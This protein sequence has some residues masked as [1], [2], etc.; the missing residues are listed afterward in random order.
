V[1]I[2]QAGA[3]L[4]SFNTDFLLNSFEICVSCNLKYFH[5]HDV[6]IYSYMKTKIFNI[7]IK[8]EAMQS[9]SFFS[10]FQ[11]S[12]LT[13]LM[14]MYVVGVSWQEPPDPSVK[15]KGHLLLIIKTTVRT[16]SCVGTLY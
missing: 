16:I 9:Q 12:K 8:S 3:S 4:A 10:N 11:A 1:L 2:L 6:D 7:V 5:N 13:H 15:D 14:F